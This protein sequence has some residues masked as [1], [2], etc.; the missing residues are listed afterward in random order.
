VKRSPA[1]HSRFVYLVAIQ[2][3]FIFAALAL[4]LFYPQER[5]SVGED[6]LRLEKRYGQLTDELALQIQ[7]SPGDLT[8]I[9]DNPA[10]GQFSFEVL[11]LEHVTC[12]EVFIDRADSVVQSLFRF[13]VERIQGPRIPGRTVV[14][15]D[16]DPRIVRSALEHDPG[17]MVPTLQNSN[18]ATYYY[19][20][21]LAE[22]VPAV[23]VTVVGH[24]LYISNRSHLAY[25]MSMLLLASI[26]VTLMTAYFVSNK[27][28]EPIRRLIHGLKLTRDG[29]LH[30]LVETG[31]D[32]ELRELE[33]AYN[34]M[35]ET[36][37]EN[38]DRLQRANRNYA[39]SNAMLMQWQMFLGTLID[40]TVAGVLTVSADGELLLYNRRAQELFGWD[41]EEVLG[42]PVCQ[43]F[44]DNSFRR[45]EQVG[46]D[47]RECEFEVL[48]VTRD[49]EQFPAY[50]TVV[51]LHNTELQMP[52]FLL[53]VRDISESKS[54]QEMMIRIDR[55]YTRGE[56]VGDIAHEINNYLAILQGNIELMP[57][58][59]KKSKTEKIEK[60]LEL[61]RATVGRIARFSDGLQDQE[62]DIRFDKTDLNQLIQNLM[63]FLGPQNRFDYIDVEM[64]LSTELPLVALDGAAIQQVLVNLLHNAADA[65]QGQEERKVII[66]SRPAPGEM[67]LIE[68]CDNGPGVPDK[69]RARLFDHQFTTKRKA[70]GFGLVTCR[71]LVELHG[72]EIEYDYDGGACFKF[73]LPLSHPDDEGPVDQVAQLNA[74]GQAG[75]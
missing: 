4:I 47:A 61:M 15:A 51:P 28:K 42:Q 41:V 1:L 32:N 16:I 39:K 35:A 14:E 44:A 46:P 9:K 53:M 34:D 55:Y 8:A 21:D 11:Q 54:F 60:K 67:A 19:R 62:D 63:A 75:V 2:V 26:L 36:L 69:D 24:D 31:G 48:C 10:V 71:K 13:P 72:G 22:S 40:H 49:N 3:T 73:T 29:R 18:F 37:W 33:Q 58:L 68:V 17:F 70:T 59:M 5:F 38:Q 52:A 25:A 64:E 45:L 65:T 30:K 43:F 74:T 12:G 20:F 57:L 23:L 66:R 7:A 56:M 27:F 6:M 50:L